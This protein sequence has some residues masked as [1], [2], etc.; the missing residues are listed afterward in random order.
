MNEKSLIRRCKNG[1]EEAFNEL[2]RLFY[3]YVS[4]YLIKLTCDEYLA[5]DLTQ[6]TFI[7]MIRGIDNYNLSSGAGFGTY[8]I[9]IAKNTYIDHY[10]R[11][12][13]ECVPIEE[14]SAGEKGFEDDVI[15]RVEYETVLAHIDKLPPQQRDVLRMKYIDEFTLREIEEITGVKQKTIKSRIHEAKKKLKRIYSN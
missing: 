7:K 15:T 8:I 13:A 5:E 11:K 3:P 1:D 4:K 10:R 12:R 6:E 14:V 2:I 9:T